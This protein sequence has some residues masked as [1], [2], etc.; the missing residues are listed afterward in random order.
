MEGDSGY[1]KRVILA[2][3]TLILAGGNNVFCSTE[4]ME[5]AGQSKSPE[6]ETTSEEEKSRA[7]HR[8]QM[9]DTVRCGNLNKE[10]QNWSYM[11]RDKIRLILEELMSLWLVS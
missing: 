6:K 10:L 7:I 4:I 11:G 8:I 5:A 1:I 9:L 3:E 2:V